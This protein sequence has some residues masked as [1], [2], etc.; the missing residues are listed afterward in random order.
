M[1][2]LDRFPS[3]T[4]KLT[5]LGCLENGAARAHTLCGEGTEAFTKSC[6][7][8]AYI[9]EV[10]NIF[11][12]PQESDLSLVEFERLKQGP[13]MPITKYPAKKLLPSTKQCLILEGASLS[14][15]S[16]RW[17]RGSTVPT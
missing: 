8:D 2:G 4:Q 17:R 5:F 13:N 1:S 11:N 6:D 3:Q 16:G 7:L 12:P 15:S 14:T 10:R 9:T